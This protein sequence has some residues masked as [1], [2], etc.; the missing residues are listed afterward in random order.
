M[1][2]NAGHSSAESTMSIVDYVEHHYFPWAE[3]ELK[4]S[5][6]NG[7]KGIFR[8]YLKPRLG[9]VALRDYSCGQAMKLLVDI[10]QDHR[11]KHEILA[12]LQ[13]PAANHLRACDPDGRSRKQQ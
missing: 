10:Y 12:T 5:T 3:T 6:V 2:V 4:A 13:N 9:F 7:Y 8:M 1:A 11:V